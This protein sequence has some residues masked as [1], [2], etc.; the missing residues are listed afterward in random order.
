M[1]EKKV[2]ARFL[3]HPRY[4]PSWVGL[5]LL[6]LCSLLPLPL[7]WLMG[8][9]IGQALYHLHRTRRAIVLTNVALCFPALSLKA[10]QRLARRHFRALGQGL[11]D[12]T[13]AWWASR[14]R[15]QRLVRVRGREN[16]DAALASKR[17]VVLLAGHFMALEVGGMYLSFERPL[18][19]MYKKSKNPVFERVL[20]RARTRFNAQIIEQDEGLKPVIQAIKK[21]GLF[22]YLPDQDFGAKRS[23]FAPFFGVAAATVPLLQRLANRAQAVVVP[24]FTRQLPYGQGY[25]IVFL[26]PLRECIP[27]DVQDARQLNGEIEKGV[28]LMPEQY[29]WVHKRFKT[30]P[31]GEASLYR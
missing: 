17:N 22:Y 3:G 31:L 8:S 20:Q 1:T 11:F 4:W 25:E 16:Y 27:G 13:L 21:V 28:R 7:L 24:C 30:R 18:A 14:R 2:S 5:A 19:T 9:V 26:P 29:F 10:Q 23:V 6:R 12:V 15:L